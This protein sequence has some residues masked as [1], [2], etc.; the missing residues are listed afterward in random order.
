MADVF[1]IW[2]L[3]EERVCHGHSD[4]DFQTRLGEIGCRGEAGI[5]DLVVERYQMEDLVLT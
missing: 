2:G 4:D 3:C 1:P 5:A